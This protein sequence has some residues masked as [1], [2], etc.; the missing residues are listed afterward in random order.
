L[1]AALLHAARGAGRVVVVTGD[2]GHVRDEGTVQVSGGSGDRWRSD[3]APLRDNEVALSG[4]RVLSPSGGR[5]VIAAW[6]ERVRFSA[7]RGGYHG[8]AS[9]QE[10]LIPIAVL[11]AGIA[12][13]GWVEAPPVEPPWWR[14]EDAVP[15]G[16]SAPSPSLR[17]RER[18][19]Q[20]DELFTGGSDPEGI[21]NL[22]EQRS[23]CPG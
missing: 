16:A 14:G 11:S 4:G 8:G 9:P 18:K 20:Q 19:R 12:P 5:S 22:V 7:R 15:P 1:V 6:S 2:H 21:Q 23:H 13:N 10:V 3:G 17:R